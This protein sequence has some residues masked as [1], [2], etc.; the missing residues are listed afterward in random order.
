MAVQGWDRHAQRAADRALRVVR[1]TDWAC[2]QSD[3]LISYA[4]VLR[5]VGR[6]EDA[7]D[8]LREALGVAQ[9]K[10]YA[11]AVRR[12]QAALDGA[13]DAQRVI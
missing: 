11:V 7:L 5:L 4:E 8:S 6:E 10:G 13:P 9:A 2:L 3:T 12:A 1:R